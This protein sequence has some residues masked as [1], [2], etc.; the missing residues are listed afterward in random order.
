MAQP[1]FIFGETTHW[2]NGLEKETYSLGVFLAL[3]ASFVTGFCPFL[4]AN[5][6]DMPMA[7]FML[8]SG[9]A[10]MILG[11]ICPA[12]GL[13]NNVQ[14]LSKLV[15]DLRVLTLVS[16]A[17]MLGLLFMQLAVAVSNDPLLVS[18]TRS[19]EIVM[20]LIVDM[21][22][23]VQDYQDMYIWYKIMGALIVT[24]CVMCISLS[25]ILQERLSRL[26]TSLSWS[27][28]E[29]YANLDESERLIDEEAEAIL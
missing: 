15:E 21:A 26:L 3:I 2:W 13:A 20:A 5:C 18:V 29:G 1:T 7:Y 6:K 23:T 8:C 4:Q 16:A 11:L 9:I 14:N 25:D 12:F 17:S 24:S 19:M 28:R 22:T 10:K 27:Y